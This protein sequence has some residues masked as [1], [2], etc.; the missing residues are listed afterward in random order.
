ML[1]AAAATLALM[2]TEP[3]LPT[4]AAVEKPM[5]GLGTTASSSFATPIHMLLH[6]RRP[7]H[8]LS[9]CLEATAFTSGQAPAPLLFEVQA[10]RTLHNL[11]KTTSSRK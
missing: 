5:A 3:A 7:D 9:P 6:L 2:E 8:R 10:W 11:M 4:R 1:A